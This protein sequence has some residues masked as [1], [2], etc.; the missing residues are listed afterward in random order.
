MITEL[1]LDEFRKIIRN[2][3]ILANPDVFETDIKDGLFDPDFAKALILLFR[4][5][6]ADDIK[7]AEYL[8][9]KLFYHYL[10]NLTGDYGF[11]EDTA[12]DAVNMW[13]ITYGEEICK[14][15]NKMRSP[16]RE[17]GADIKADIDEKK[18]MGMRVRNINTN[19]IG[20]I[21]EIHDGLVIVDFHGAISKYSYPTAF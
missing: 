8:D 20:I 17:D 13:F 1:E 16:N 15:E 18:L 11:D 5:E 14:K 4:L 9:E 3:D 2:D 7:N 12:S 19:A 10:G 21:K 6:I